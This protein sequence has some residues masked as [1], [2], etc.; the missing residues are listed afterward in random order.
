MRVVTKYDAAQPREQRRRLR[1]P[2]ICEG[3]EEVFGGGGGGEEAGV[4][5]IEVHQRRARLQDLVDAREVA[6]EGNH[7]QWGAGEEG[8]ELGGEGGG[9]CC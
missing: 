6:G 7:L 1:I 4:S 8:C 5:E 3:G 2:I 9:G